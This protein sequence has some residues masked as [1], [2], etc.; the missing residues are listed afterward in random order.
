MLGEGAV[1]LVTLALHKITKEKVAIKQIDL[2]ESEDILESGV[3]KKHG[4]FT[5]IAMMYEYLE[6]IF[7]TLPNEKHENRKQTKNTICITVPF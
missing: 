1:G 5:N 3:N 4:I 2:Q 6:P 7:C